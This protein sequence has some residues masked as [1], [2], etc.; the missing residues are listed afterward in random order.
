MK[1]DKPRPK[2]EAREIRELIRVKIDITG[3]RQEDIDYLRAHANS[4]LDKRTC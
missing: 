2:K 3:L 4:V 1:K